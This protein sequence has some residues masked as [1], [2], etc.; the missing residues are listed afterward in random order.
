MSE[1]RRDHEAAGEFALGRGPRPKAVFHR[2]YDLATICGDIPYRTIDPDKEPFV[3][4]GMPGKKM[5]GRRSESHPKGMAYAELLAGLKR[6]PVLVDA[7]SQ[8]A[9]DAADHQQRRNEAQTRA[10]PGC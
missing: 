7:K 8:I 4:L 1:P 5:T 9:L 2:R 6:Y 10:R 3:P